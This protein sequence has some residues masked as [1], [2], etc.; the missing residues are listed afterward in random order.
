[1]F[2]LHSSAL[3]FKFVKFPLFGDNDVLLLRG[4]PRHKYI[5]MILNVKCPTKSR[6]DRGILRT[7]F[8]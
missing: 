4:T 5:L 1:M 3:S 6:F 2:D 7:I 8:F